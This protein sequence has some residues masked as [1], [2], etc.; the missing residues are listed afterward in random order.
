MRDRKVVVPLLCAALSAFSVAAVSVMAQPKPQSRESYLETKLIAWNYAHNNTLH[1]VSVRRHSKDTLYGVTH[2]LRLLQMIR[3]KVSGKV[4]P[5]YLAV[6]L[7]AAT[8][9]KNQKSAV[10]RYVRTQLS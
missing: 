3:D 8:A 1:R 7:F 6:I 9:R 2:Q 5:R 4:V 10:D